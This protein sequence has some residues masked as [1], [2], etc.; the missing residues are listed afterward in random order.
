M[1]CGWL[2]SFLLASALL[3]FSQDVLV[4]KSQRAK[5]A[6]LD[7]HFDEAERLYSE[8]VRALPQNP[9]MLMNLGL[10]Q[11]SAGRYREAITTF[12]A[13][14]KLQPGL[15]EAKFLTGVAYLKLGEPARAIGPLNDTLKAAPG[16]RMAM[17]ELA[18]ALLSTGRCKEAVGHF[19]KLAELEPH[20]ARAWQGLG[21]SYLGLARESFAAL[22]KATPDSPYVLALLANSRAQEGQFRR[23]FLLYRQALAKDSRFRGAHAALAEVYRNTG[24]AEWAGVEEQR[25]RELPMPDCATAPAE[26]AFMAGHYEQAFA[27]PPSP[28]TLY[29]NSR[30]YSELA[31][32]ALSHLARLPPSP[33]I[34]ELIAEAYTV[35]GQH[36]QAAEEV[37]EALRLDPGNSRLQALL[38]ASLWRNRDFE[39][40]LPLLIKLVSNNPNS[41]S[42]NFEL[43]DTLLQQEEVEKALPPLQAAVRIKPDLLPAQASLGRAYMRSGDTNAAIPHLKAALPLDD[44]GSLHFQLSRAYERSGNAILAREALQQFQSI[45]LAHAKR[46]IVEDELTISPP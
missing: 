20:D 15:M 25:E 36:H 44:D 8:L 14:M 6:M 45:S 40:A 28:P 16:H 30:S 46:K 33:Q 10:A 34:H 11:H 24:H 39:A 29:W 17:L 26:C 19:R 42:L 1:Q 35:Q 22:E 21:L 38:A 18:D 37:I 31:H 32:A 7:R 41:A 9:G 12:A 4:V 3:V 13:A 5:Q 43:G 2:R 27:L 23:A